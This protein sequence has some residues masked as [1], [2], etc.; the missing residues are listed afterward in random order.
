MI[1]DS[2]VSFEETSSYIQVHFLSFLVCVCLWL[3]LYKR[4]AQMSTKM[5]NLTSEQVEM[6]KHFLKEMIFHF[7]NGQNFLSSYENVTVS[8]RYK[9][10][11]LFM[12]FLVHDF[13]F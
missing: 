13:I 9:S 7:L 1:L 6:H 5:T 8:L 2:C 4:G 11:I 3:S 10:I 12:F